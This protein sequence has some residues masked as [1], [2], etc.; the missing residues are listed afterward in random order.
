MGIDVPTELRKDMAMAGEWTVTNTRVVEE[1]PKTKEDTTV[2]AI[3]TGVRKRPKVEG[4]DE[5]EN[6]FSGLFKRPKRWGRDTR[7][8]PDDDAELDALLSGTLMTKKEEKVE[9]VADEVKTE[10]DESSQP[11][12]KEPQEDDQLP[13]AIK[14]EAGIKLEESSAAGVEVPAV[15]FKKRKPKNIRQK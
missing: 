5:V 7:D 4:E 3:A 14:S 6:A 2:D 11:L 10:Q 1:T 12:K 8:A 9:P 13:E 15:V